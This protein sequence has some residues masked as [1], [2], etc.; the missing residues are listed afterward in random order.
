MKLIGSLLIGLGAFITLPGILKLA[1]GGG[2]EL[3]VTLTFLV[4]GPAL[5]VLGLYVR[6]KSAAVS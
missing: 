4:L 6:R 5:V 1:Y 3:A 2:E